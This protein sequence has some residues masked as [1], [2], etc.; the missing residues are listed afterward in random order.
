MADKIVVMHGGIVEQVG[1]PLELYDR[2]ANQFVA[3]FLGS[4]SMNFLSGQIVQADGLH[5][6]LAP[7]MAIALPANAAA[8]PGPVVLGIRPEDIVLAPAGIPA[9]IKVVEPTGSETHM[10]VSVAEQAMTIVLRDRFSG[11]VGDT[12]KIAIPPGKSHLF[13]AGTGIRI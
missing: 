8:R 12:I 1:S 10:A 4:P 2:P 3:G 6:Q 7:D 5:F 13:N 11:Q 9:T